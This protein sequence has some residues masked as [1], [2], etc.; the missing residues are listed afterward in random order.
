MPPVMGVA[1]QHTSGHDGLATLCVV[2]DVVRL[3]PTRW[4]LAPADATPALTFDQGEVLLEQEQP[5]STSHVD[6]RATIVVIEPVA[7]GSAVHLGE[8]GCVEHL[9]GGRH[10]PAVPTARD[11]VVGGDA[12]DDRTA[13]HLR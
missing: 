2:V 4:C 1:Q 11:H 12:D 3:T 13:R 8:L 5:S 7:V 9:A 10:S 6:R